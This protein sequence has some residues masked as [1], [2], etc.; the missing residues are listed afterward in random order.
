MNL[1]PDEKINEIR[2]LANIVDIV[3]SYI[4]LTNKGKNYFGVCPFHDD[5]SPSMSVSP[6]RQMFKCFTCGVGGNVFNFVS[7]YENITFIEAVKRVADYVGVDLD[8]T[9][10]EKKETAYKHEFEIM[11]FATKVYQNNLNT[12]LGAVSRE[13]LKNRSINESIISTFK[14]GFAINDNKN[15][16]NILSKKYKNK[17]LEELGLI[18]L[19]GIDGY[20]KFVNRI[21]IP[22]TDI[23]NN[24]VGFTGRIINNDSDQPKY[25]NTKETKIYKKGNIL[26]NYFNAKQYIKQ[27]KKVV[28]VEG[29]MDAIRLYASGIK[30]VVAL[31]GTS[32]TKEQIT[33]LKNLRVPVILMLDNDNAGEMAT[34]ANG[35]QLHSYNIDTYVVRLSD[36]KDPDEYI[37]KY[38]TDKLNDLINHPISYMDYKL[39]SLK[40]EFNLNNPIELSKYINSI[41]KYLKDK[42]NITKEVTIR[43]ISDEYNIDYEVLK[44]ELKLEEKIENVKEVPTTDYVKK[45]RYKECTNEIFLYLMSDIKYISIF[46][47]KINFFRDKD[48]RE[49]YNEILY[50]SKKFKNINI[51][52]FMSFIEQTDNLKEYTNTIIS[53]MNFDNMSEDIFM[54]YINY[55]ENYFR[56]QHI[57][58]LKEQLKSETDLN[59]KCE[60]IN[61]ITKLK[62]EV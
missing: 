31:M 49:L 37:I 20:D 62:K 6:D 15:L 45:D 24:V 28:V 42:D 61:N 34:I 58:K 40:K 41:I 17:E 51:A 10:F 9:K 25:I 47:N 13:Y 7:R 5:H 35:E 26:F 39:K 14:I 3:S 44:G 52:N 18:N 12:S 32:L 4:Q 8:I 46:K 22:I 56:K 53:K 54:E 33:L 27:I 43:K 16:Y 19:N 11:E 48:E 57:K 36:A 23:N 1:I 2:G 55:L 38:G 30:N 59:K 29:N 50:Y 60:L 21:M